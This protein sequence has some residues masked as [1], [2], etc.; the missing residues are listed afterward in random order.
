MIGIIEKK[1]EA[2]AIIF[3]SKPQY[4]PKTLTPKPDG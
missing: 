4:S 3:F 1:M 2:E